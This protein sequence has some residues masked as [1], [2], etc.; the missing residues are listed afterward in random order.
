MP[1]PKKGP[2]FGGSPSHH[3]HIVGNLATE[4][5]R[6]G[7]VQTTLAKA[8]RVQP[9]ADRMVTFA[10]RGDLHARRQVHRV[11]QDR[12]VVHKLFE[13]VGPAF[14]ERN[15]GYTRVL[16]TGSRKGDRA[17]MALIELVE[18]SRGRGSGGLTEAPRRRWS[19]RRRRGTVSQSA[20]E[21]EEQEAAAEDRGES[22]GEEPA[23]VEE[24]EAGAEPGP[25]VE[26]DPTGLDPAEVERRLAQQEAE[27]AERD[28][29]TGESGPEGSPPGEPGSDESGS[30][31]DAAAPGSGGD[32]DAERDDRGDGTS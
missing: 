23:L 32:E 30:G 2:H 10:K 1:K 11:I 24:P 12:D 6:H 29:A 26:A 21:R 9:L 13:D 28:T 3:N 25:D 16:K 22:L 17:P 8:K 5:F 7:Q 27:E 19:L 20:Q 15:G 4:L 14:A 18:G 31:G